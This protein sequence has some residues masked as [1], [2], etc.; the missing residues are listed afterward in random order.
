[1]C[2][3]SLF[4]ICNGRFISIYPTRHNIDL[5]PLQKQGYY[6]KYLKGLWENYDDTSGE[7]DNIVDKMWEFES[8]AA[9]V[10]HFLSLFTTLDWI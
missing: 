7:A 8:C 1:M 5:Q 9:E 10:T 4:L 2:E 6:K 3:Q